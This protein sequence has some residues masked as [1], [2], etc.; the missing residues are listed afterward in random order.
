MYYLAECYLEGIYGVK[1]DRKKG[2]EWLRK[3]E[4]DEDNTEAVELLMKYE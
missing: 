4:A 1:Q 3:A 2:L